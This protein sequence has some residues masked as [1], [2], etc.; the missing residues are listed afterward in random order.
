MLTTCVTAALLL[1]V[2]VPLLLTLDATQGPARGADILGLIPGLVKSTLSPLSC[3]C[4]ILLSFSLLLDLFV[5]S[6]LRCAIKAQS[7]FAS[8]GNSMSLPNAN[9]PGEAFDAA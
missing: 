1:I 6:C 7:A 5:V 4:C 2:I 8:T 3:L 9:C